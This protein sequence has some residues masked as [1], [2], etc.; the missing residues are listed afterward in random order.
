MRT[1]INLEDY[2][3]EI[4]SRVDGDYNRQTLKNAIEDFLDEECYRC[5]N[6]QIK[7]FISRYT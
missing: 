6:F 7:E 5:E 2:E 4:L 1:Y 3:D